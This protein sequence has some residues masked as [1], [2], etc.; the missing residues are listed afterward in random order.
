MRVLPISAMQLLLVNTG[1]LARLF[2]RQE[3]L[4]AIVNVSQLAVNKEHLQR[5]ATFIG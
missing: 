5:L 4:P 1:L 3:A 2:N